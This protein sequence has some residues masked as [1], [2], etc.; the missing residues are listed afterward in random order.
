M[1]NWRVVKADH[2]APSAAVRI[3]KELATRIWRNPKAG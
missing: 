2:M 3:R 1:P